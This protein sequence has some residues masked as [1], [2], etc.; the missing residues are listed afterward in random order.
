MNPSIPGIVIGVIVAAGLALG[1]AFSSGRIDQ[2]AGP[3][4]SAASSGK[5]ASRAEQQQDN[6]APRDPATS[7][8]AT[9]GAAPSRPPPLV[10]FAL[11]FGGGLSVQRESIRRDSCQRQPTMNR[12][13][14]G[15]GTF[16][17]TLRFSTQRRR[18]AI[19]LAPLCL[20]AS[21]LLG[22]V[23]FAADGEREEKLR[24]EAMQDR[25][26]GRDQDRDSAAQRQHWLYDE[27]T[28]RRPPAR[29]PPVSTANPNACV[30]P[31]AMAQARCVNR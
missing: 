12:A 14:L 16:A 30:C 15:I 28:S 17:G 8:S 24:G 23:A 11:K 27:K 3:T 6:G 7:G 19:E 21:C 1:S 26:Q 13:L 5:D 22:S 20:L 10:Q 4:G 2:T 29:P 31:A 18:T 25:D 9:D